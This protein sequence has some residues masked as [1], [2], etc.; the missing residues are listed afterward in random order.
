MCLII[1]YAITNESLLTRD[2][3]AALINE[4]HTCLKYCYRLK[5]LYDFD[6]EHKDID[7]GRI[8]RPMD[9][10]RNSILHDGFAID[11]AGGVRP[12]MTGD[13][14]GD[15][16]QGGLLN[17]MGTDMNAI[18]E[19]DGRMS[20]DPADSAQLVRLGSS[21]STTSVVEEEAAQRRRLIQQASL[22]TISDSLTHHNSVR[23]KASEQPVFF[24]SVSSMSQDSNYDPTPALNR[25][26][27]KSSSTEGDMMRGKS[28]NAGKI[29][30]NP[31]PD[32][33]PNANPHLNPIRKS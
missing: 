4:N 5:E 18:M 20:F 27:S 23:S 6:E 15:P 3:V 1:S 14:H 25:L 33:N 30:R 16:N 29:N 21:R 8:S 7:E 22:H 24:R 9:T 26:F 2:V 12:S 17:E 13:A 28:A 19:E 10:R 32:P 11:F 31:N